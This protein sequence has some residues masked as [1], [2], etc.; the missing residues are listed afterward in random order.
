MNQRVK[1]RPDN[2]MNRLASRISGNGPTWQKALRW[3]GAVTV[4]GTVL[5]AL[6]FFVLYLLIDMPDPNRDFETQSTKVYYSD[7][8]H[9]IGTFAIQDRENVA[10]DEV[11]KE[12]QAAVIAAEDRTFYSNRGI[13]IRGIIRAARDNAQSRAITGGGSTITQQYVKILYLSQER[14]YT[15]KIARGDPLDQDPQP[16][17]QAGDPR[18]LPQPDL[19]RQRLPTASRS[20]RR[21]TST[22]R[23][24]SSTSRKQRCWPTI[25]NRPSFY[26]PYLEGG[27]ERMHAALQLRARRHGKGGRDQ[28]LRRGRG[29]KDL[30]KFAKQ[31]H[32]NRFKGPK[33]H[34]LRFVQRPDDQARIHRVRHPGWWPTIITT[35]GYEKQLAAIERSNRPPARHRSCTSARLHRARQR[36]RARHV[37]RPGLH[38]EPLNWATSGTQPGSTFKAFAL[39]AA[40]EDGFSLK[41][42][43]NGSS[44]IGSACYTIENQGDSGGKSFGRVSLQYATEKS[45][46]TAFVDLTLQM[47]T[48]EDETPAPA[49]STGSKTTPRPHRRREEDP[50]GRQAAGIPKSYTTRSILSPP[51]R[52][53]THRSRR[54]TWRTATR[55]WRPGACG[56]SGTSS[57]TS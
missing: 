36:R 42:R 40:L 12:M 3:V 32:T 9:Q 54:S 56:P 52:W 5:G 7:G 6:T 48:D 10:L 24:P 51:R 37:R 49:G 2:A 18:G 53:A 16:D 47:G 34:V 11:S 35:I 15:R 45:I 4:G 19:L 23:P 22:S 30:P 55:P 46:N 17:D 57:T 27:A 28:R 41:S 31:K 14:S 39:I 43:L 25:L 21:R 44:P 26:D 29:G 20:R 50:R 33:G 1:P 38:E 13:D 8:K